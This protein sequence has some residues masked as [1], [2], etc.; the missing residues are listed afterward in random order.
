M[1]YNQKLGHIALGGMFMLIGM[2]VATT[3]TS[4]LMAQKS[5]NLSGEMESAVFDE[6]TC[7]KLTVVGENGGAA[8][9]V[10]NDGHPGV[11]LL[12]DKTESPRVALGSGE[13][14]GIVAVYNN[15]A[16]HAVGLLISEAGGLV[17]VG[18]RAENVTGSLP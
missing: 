3:M 16:N 2:V 5:F 13:D 15:T 6:F 10:N 17:V 12:N 8:T 1:N 11:L 9:L 7:R 4:N 14:G 18:D